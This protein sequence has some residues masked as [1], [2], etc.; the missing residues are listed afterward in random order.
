MPPNGTARKDITWETNKALEEI[1]K[2]GSTPYGMIP[3]GTMMGV[4]HHSLILMA[5][6]MVGLPIPG[7]AFTDGLE[8]VTAL[9]DSPMLPLE[10]LGQQ[11]MTR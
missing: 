11:A 3:D 4:G 8:I 6:K 1:M 7:V 9:V 5:W 10:R 2:I